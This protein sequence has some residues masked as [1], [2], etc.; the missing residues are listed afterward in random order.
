MVFGNS[1]L[2]RV[3]GKWTWERWRMLVHKRSVIV[4]AKYLFLF[5][6]DVDLVY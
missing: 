3:I 6:L 2:G 5:F 4:E 1:G